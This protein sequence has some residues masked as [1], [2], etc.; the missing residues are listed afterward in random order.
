MACEKVTHKHILHLRFFPEFLK[1][2]FPDTK[3]KCCSCAIWSWYEKQ[4]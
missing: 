3:T 1:L 4:H 2:H